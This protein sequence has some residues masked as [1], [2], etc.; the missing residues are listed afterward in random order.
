MGEKI[1]VDSATMMNKGL[2]VIEAHWLFDLPFDKIR[3]VIHP[4]SIIHSLVELRDNSLIAQMGLPDMRLPILYALGYPERIDTDMAR[5]DLTGYPDLTFAEVE[6]ARYPCLELA[7]EAGNRG[8]NAPT[9]LN[10]ANE[11]AVGAFLADRISFS[12]ICETI[13]TAMDG[14]PYADI[15]SFEDV[16]ETHRSTQEYIKEK[17]GV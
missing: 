3:I 1:T 6:G 12:Q 13:A 16:L 14:I 10:S 2:E 5:S 9:V 8:G 7:L 4:Q 15:T 17:F 11:M